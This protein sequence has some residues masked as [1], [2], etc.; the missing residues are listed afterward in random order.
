MKFP[1]RL[2]EITT[3]DNLV[4]QGFIYIPKRKKSVAIL[5]IHGLTG[6]FYKNCKIHEAFI[7]MCSRNGFSYAS[8]NTRG[9]DQITS[10]RKIDPLKDSGYAHVNGGGGYES[11]PLSILDIDAAVSFLTKLGFKKIILLG[12]S[13]GANKACYYSIHNPSDLRVTAVILA[14]PISDR[15]GL[16][17]WQ[18][19]TLAIIWI[20]KIFG[21]KAVLY[22][23]KNL[24]FP[25]TVGRAE[26]LVMPGSDEDVF[27]YADSEDI[28]LM[29]F[30]QMNHP[31]TVVLAGDDEL[32]DR[33]ISII[34]A[35]FDS[36]AP[37]HGYES[38]I[39]HDADHGF[40]GKEKE[41]ASLVMHA[42]NRI[43]NRKG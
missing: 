40:G 18:K 30:S 38:H 7:A 26:S 9:H 17:I 12:H 13:T 24:F 21:N 6:S 19:P 5:W 29:R 33:P 41:F 16:G 4:H 1:V 8:I 22:Q 42:I 34:K 27:N 2:I 23:W 14:S 32:A 10:I 28:R 39:I 43:I 25:A 15:L 36:H 37:S 31:V 35:A 20:R 11:F 3:Q